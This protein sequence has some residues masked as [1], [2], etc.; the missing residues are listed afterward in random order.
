MAKA[1]AVPPA[2]EAAGET[3]AAGESRAEDHVLIAA[4][5]GGD[6]R[7]FGRLMR[8]YEERVRS[9][10]GRIVGDEQEAED[11]TQEVFI[12][13]F[14]SLPD[15]EHT[16]AFY[17]WIYRITQNCC[18]DRIRKLKRRAQEVSLTP[19]AEDDSGEIPREHSIPDETYVPEKQALNSELRK[20]IEA[21]LA[22]LSPKLR[23]IVELKEQ[24]GLSYD[25]IAEALHCSRG[26]V[27]SRLFRARE[28]LQALLIEY[29]PE[30][31]AGSTPPEP[32]GDEETGTRDERKG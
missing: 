31:R 3:G 19:A 14:R 8:K 15:Y 25:E 22:R 16:Y 11:L 21:A 1:R 6:E 4:A 17:T 12:K 13:V 28:K 23:E 2:K 20:A 5:K 30:D 10:C 27:K 18:I 26:T 7:A 32:D 29:A 24:K 9:H